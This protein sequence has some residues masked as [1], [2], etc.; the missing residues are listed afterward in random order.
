MLLERTD[1]QSVLPEMVSGILQHCVDALLVVPLLEE[2]LDHRRVLLPLLLVTGARLGDDAADVT[3]RVHQL[4]FDGLFQGL[5]GG[6]AQR[7]TTTHAGPEVCDHLLAKAVGSR[8]DNRD[9]L[10]DG[11]EEPLVGLHL[12]LGHVI[13]DLGLGHVGLGIVEV[14][15]EECLRLILEAKDKRLGD[16][17]L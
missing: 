11:F 17:L 13:L 3:D 16:V 6:V 15:L 8:A 10:L 4:L 9:L 12:L 7:L 14:V 1:H 2:I 5:V